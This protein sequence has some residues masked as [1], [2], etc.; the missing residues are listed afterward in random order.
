MIT[1][2]PA[3]DA[4]TPG[5]IGRIPVRNIWLLLL[6]ASKLYQELP[7]ARRVELENAPDDI[8]ELVAEILAG[9]VARRLRRNLNSDYQRR[10]HDLNRV[11][12][13][14][15]LLRTERRQLLQ[16][17][18]VACIYDELTVDT[19]RNRYVKAALLRL[20]QV[21]QSKRQPS[22]RTIDLAHRC[23]HL[24]AR[25]E[26]AGVSSEP[27]PRQLNRSTPPDRLGWMDAEERRMLAAARLA[28]DFAIPTEESG[29]SL[30][31]IVNRTETRGWE[32]YE[33]A[34]AGF[35]DAVLSP[36][37]WQVTAQS[38]VNWQLDDPTPGLRGLMPGMVRDVVLERGNRRIVIDTKFTSIMT[39]GQWDNRSLQSSH[40][41]Q[42][43]AYLRSQEQADDPLSLNTAGVLLYPSLGVEY[44]EAATIQGHEIRFAT[45]N[46]AADSRTIRAQLLRIV[47]DSSAP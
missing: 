1:T 39:S 12:G 42:I 17:A 2:L 19:P 27:D 46:L 29:A 18:R 9:A 34:V 31:P 22:S 8:P 25:L 13:R 11:R 16:R 32:L 40:I 38:P 28:L 43:Y 5:L 21:L 37:G 33:R 14:I 23:R 4:T 36:D 15:N 24:A 41:Y 35:Y 44:D 47:D 30:L 7:E 20:A 10:H 6:Y 3:A 26:R 45:V